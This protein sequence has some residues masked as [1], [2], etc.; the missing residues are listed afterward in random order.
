MRTGR[1]PKAPKI[2]RVCQQCGKEWQAY[3]WVNVVLYCSRACFYKSRIGRKRAI[4]PGKREHR[5][6]LQCGKT[7]IVGG[8]GNRP[9]IA[10]YCS[11]T[12]SRKAYWINVRAGETPP[13][14]NQTFDGSS[15]AMP[16]E[17]SE[18]ERTWFAGLFDG[19]GCV[20]WPR[21]NVLHSVYL[22]ITNTNENLMNRVAEI[23]GTGRIKYKHRDSRHSPIWVWA[24]YGENARSILRQ[25]VPW[26]I[27]KKEAAEVALGI[28][29]A[30]EP[31]WTQRSK[32]MRKANRRKR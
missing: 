17:M 14:V 15:H 27:V 29:E 26:L 9:Y 30:K 32:T 18:I 3:E 28:K 10:K 6:C 21:R 7:F 23:T 2:T 1:P 24:C 22:S 31:P 19:E 5:A 12:C 11:R 20:G 16:R 4:D 25:I 8:G 13:P